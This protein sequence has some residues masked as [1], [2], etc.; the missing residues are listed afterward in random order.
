MRSR[1]PFLLLFGLG[2]CSG[3]IET[4]I[5]SSGPGVANP[6]YILQEEPPKADLP[7]RAHIAVMHQL[8]DRG[9]MVSDTGSLKLDIAFAE[10]DAQIA[11]FTKSGSDQA[12]I[13]PG[14][15]KKALQSCADREMRLTVILTRIADGVELYRGNASEYHCKA[16]AEDVVP[17]LVK[18]ALVDLTKPKGAYSITRQGLA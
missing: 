2:A 7:L 18:A 14:K 8:A 17:E 13:A 1:L 3:P 11:V 15:Q 4:R 12:I 10:R 16:K 6:E 5:V 9:Y